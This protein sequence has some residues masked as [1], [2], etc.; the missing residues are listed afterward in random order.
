MEAV[1]DRQVVVGAP[2]RR[3]EKRR[4]SAVHKLRLLPEEDE[5]L[6]AIVAESGFPTIQAYLLAKL[7]PEVTAC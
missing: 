7:P 3:I 4:R 1:A 6:R 5:R 2:K